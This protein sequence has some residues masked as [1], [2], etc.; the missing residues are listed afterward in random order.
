M[1]E[2]TGRRGPEP[3]SAGVH[4]GDRFGSAGMVD[5]YGRGNSPFLSGSFVRA[6]IACRRRS[7]SAA[8]DG[9]T[10]AQRIVSRDGLCRA[11]P[12]HRAITA[13]AALARQPLC[14]G[15]AGRG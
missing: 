2:S 5:T 11:A 13:G 6:W 7:A 14:V 10:L 4:A 15:E 3:K 12:A 8:G 9:E 1:D